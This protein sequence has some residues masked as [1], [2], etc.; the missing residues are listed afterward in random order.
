MAGQIVCPQRE[1]YYGQQRLLSCRKK[2]PSVTTSEQLNTNLL[3]GDISLLV[4]DAFHLGICRHQTA[5][6]IDIW[7]RLTDKSLRMK[8]ASCRV[9]V[10]DLTNYKLRQS[11]WTNDH[12]QA[13]PCR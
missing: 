9:S 11:N 4:V 13:P 8:P 5:E 2:A 12:F 10:V 1:R 3:I 6:V 7:L